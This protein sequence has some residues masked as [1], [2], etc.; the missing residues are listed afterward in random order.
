MTRLRVRDVHGEGEKFVNLLNREAVKFPH[1]SQVLV[2]K[3]NLIVQ[4]VCTVNI[5]NDPS[6]VGGRW[7]DSIGIVAV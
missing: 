1:L 6:I 5:S 7:T 3:H 2:V 4:A